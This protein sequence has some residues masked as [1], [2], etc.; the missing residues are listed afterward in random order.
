MNWLK[1]LLKAI[2]LI[3]PIV[4]AVQVIS[5]ENASGADK[6]TLA[7]SA[8]QQASG[9]A[10]SQLS[11]EDAAKAA[12]ITNVVSAGIDATVSALKDKGT[13][14]KIDNVATVGVVGAAEVAATLG[15]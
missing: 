9:I 1:V 14:G 4:Q 13:L 3:H 12:A 10:Q 5:D 6:K 11:T 8:I 2:G 15:Q 7:L